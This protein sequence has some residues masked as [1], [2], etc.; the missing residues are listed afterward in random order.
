LE[1]LTCSVVVAKGDWSVIEF[2]SISISR[3]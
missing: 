1:S 2:H 3:H